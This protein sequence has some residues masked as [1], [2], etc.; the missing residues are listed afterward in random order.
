RAADLCLEIVDARLDEPLLLARRVILGVLAEIAVRACLRDRFDDRRAFDALEP[1]ELRG[2]LVE[3]GP[4]HR[5]ALDRHGANTLTR[6]AET[7]RTLSRGARKREMRRSSR[8]GSD[9]EELGPEQR[10]HGLTVLI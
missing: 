7:P 8:A 4:R 10:H 2:E 3:P 6:A 9:A 5:R 1:I